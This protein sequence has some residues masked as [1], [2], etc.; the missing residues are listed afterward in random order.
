[1]IFVDI[2]NHVLTRILTRFGFW[3]EEGCGITPNRL[4]GNDVEN[5]LIRQKLKPKITYF[6]VAPSRTYNPFLT[7]CLISFFE[8]TNQIVSRSRSV[9][10]L[11]GNV[12]IISG[13]LQRETPIAL[14][15]ECY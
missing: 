11:C 14:D 6:F 15:H 9:G 1:V 3:R 4:N 8:L 13:T 5:V 12:A 10:L 2:V 7:R